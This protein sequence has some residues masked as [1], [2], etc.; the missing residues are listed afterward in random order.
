L[1][2]RQTA[3]LSGGEHRALVRHQAAESGTGFGSRMMIGGAGGKVVMRLL[4]HKKLSTT[5]RHVHTSDEHCRSVVDRLL[6][7]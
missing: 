7:R 1:W 4:G 3:A 5:E 2:V 6:P